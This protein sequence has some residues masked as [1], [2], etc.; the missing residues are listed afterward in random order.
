VIVMVVIFFATIITT[1]PVLALI[2]LK[3]LLKNELHADRAATAAFFFW[4]QLAWYF[5]PFAGIVTDAF[6]ILGTRR[7][8]YMLIGAVLTVACWV[9]LYFTPHQYNKL[10]WVCA[11]ITVFT[12]I[13]STAAGGYMVEVAQTFAAP[14]RL[15]AVHNFV[16]MLTYVIAGPLGG[17]LGAVAFGW[18]AAINGAIMFLVMPVT[19]IFL[20]EQRRKIDS[21][22]LLAQAG[23]QLK[24]IATAK[25][26]WA[27][28]AFSALFY[29]APGIQTAIFYR[30][31]DVLHLTTKGQGILQFL[32]GVGGV[33][34]ALLYGAFACKRLKLRSLLVWC[35]ALGA[36]GQLSYIFYSTLG[37]AYVIDS[38]WGF[39]YTAADMCL[40]HLAVRATPSGSEALGFS[41]M[42]SV[43]NISMFGSDWVGSKA[44]EVYHLHFNTLVTANVLISLIA[45]PFIFR[46]PGRIVDHKDS[47]AEAEAQPA[48]V[49]HAV[50]E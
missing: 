14:G 43:R 38:F 26:M 30:Q 12:V 24:K 45:V 20:R 32:N 3:N 23:T 7:R 49:G 42:M 21:K 9:A 40:M 41:L 27:A 44:L 29:C 4:I 34:V 2:P 15:S 37:R 1:F 6:P 47:E 50:A 36:A 28:A 35:L 25:T 8:S 48:S 22:K 17:F 16:E 10:L 46:L 13:T 31:Q 5:K 18:T 19:I 11:A 39:G 33:A